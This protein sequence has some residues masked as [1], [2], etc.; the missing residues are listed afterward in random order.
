MPIARHTYF[1]F[2]RLILANKM[3]AYFTLDAPQNPRA[4][5]AISHVAISHDPNSST[6]NKIGSAFKPLTFGG[7]IIP[8]LL[9][10]S[11]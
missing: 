10:D 2:A 7:A 3:K 1:T 4:L 6:D 8:A 9:I 5:F 11:I